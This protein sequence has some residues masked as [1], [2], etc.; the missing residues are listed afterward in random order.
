MFG[1]IILWNMN[2]PR[3]SVRSPQCRITQHAAALGAETEI[4]M[5]VT[6]GT[7]CPIRTWLILDS[8]HEAS[9]LA[10]PR[11]G[12]LRLT[13]AESGYMRFD[14]T[15]DEKF[16]G[17]DRFAVALRGTLRS[18]PVTVNVMVVATVE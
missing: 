1:A 2:D 3:A 14:Y 8:V 15:P 4:K 10:P 11:F 13:Q 17:E 9:T 12:A 6:A 5:A 18:R 7:P 16:K